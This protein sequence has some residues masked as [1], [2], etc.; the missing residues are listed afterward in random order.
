MLNVSAC[1]VK[2]LF[3]IGLS[4]SKL[5]NPTNLNLSDDFF[6]Q[7]RDIFN[8]L[9]LNTNFAPIIKGYICKVRF[10]LHTSLLHSA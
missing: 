3:K 4:I 7:S 6:C 8:P 5:S 10:L 2:H 1:F 9:L